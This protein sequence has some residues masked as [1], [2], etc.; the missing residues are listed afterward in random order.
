MQ[1]QLLAAR[2]KSVPNA[3][4]AMRRAFHRKTRNEVNSELKVF[5]VN[6][7]CFALFIADKSTPFSYLNNIF[8]LIYTNMEDD[9]TKLQ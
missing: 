8:H 1:H 2:E 7:P 5:L 4:G 3:N 9:E 6:L